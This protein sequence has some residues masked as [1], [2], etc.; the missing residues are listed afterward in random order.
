MFTLGAGLARLVRQVS[1]LPI[2]LGAENVPRTPWRSGA[3]VATIAAALGMAVTLASLVQNF[4]GAWMGWLEQHFGADLFVGAGARFRLLAG[5]PMAEAIG[6]TIA[7]VPGVASVEPF[8]VMQVRLDD[9]RLVFL[10]GMSIDDRLAHGGLAMVEGTLSI[11]APALKAGAGVLVSDNLAAKMRL[12][13]GDRITIPTPTG[14][15]A[16]RVEGTYVDYVGSLDLG[17]IAIAQPLLASIWGDRSANL[18]RVW[19]E[20]GRAIS[21]VRADVLGALGGGYYV[22]SGREFL[23]GVRSV[24]RQFFHATWALQLIAALVGIIG[25]VNSQLAIVLDRRNE[26]AMLRTIGVSARDVIRSVLVECAALG[27]IGGVWGVLVGGMLGVQF[28]VVSLHLITGWR[29]PFVAPAGAAVLSVVC[30][31][32]VS[33]VAGYVPARAAGRLLLRHPESE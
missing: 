33:T 3:T 1:S 31:T 30:A 16:F 12:H 4:E 15:R 21:T 25:V 27:A 17:A 18:F 11:A 29:I 2:R 20:P 14:P 32:V 6:R 8:R 7:G 28:V 24:L 22:V 23:D 10:Q 9:G 5:P 13:R 26:I 19:I